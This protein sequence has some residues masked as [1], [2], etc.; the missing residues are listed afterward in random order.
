MNRPHYDTLGVPKDA[1]DKTI[2]KA[3]RKLAQQYHPDR[4]KDDATAEKKFKAINQAYEVLGDPEKR[5]MYDEFGD[6]AEKL[7][8]DPN[9]ARQYRQY[10]AGGGVGMD[11]GVDLEDLLSQMFGGGGGGGFGGFGGR[12]RAPR[13]GRDL[14]AALGVDFT[15]A[16]LGGERAIEI[17]GRNINVRIPPGVQDGGTLRLRGQGVPSQTGGPSGDLLL[18]IK[19]AADPHFSRDGDHLRLDV[20]ITLGEALR[21]ASIEVPTLDGKVRVKVP[22][23]TQSGRTLRVRG[24]GVARKGKTPGDLLVTLRVQLPGIEGHDVEAAIEALEALYDGDPRQGL[25][26]RAA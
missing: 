6:D 4:N 22:A 10:R 2:K 25:S 5:K 1:D 17:D 8:F 16:C 13:K 26:A 24:R 3:Y 21:G 15:T 11:G 18:E 9:K 19:V 23:G 14:R 7:G 12:A 20:P